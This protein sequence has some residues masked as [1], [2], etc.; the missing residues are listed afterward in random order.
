MSRVW[1]T[2]DTHFSHKFLALDI[3]GF[4]TIEAHDEAIVENWNS[5][6]NPDDHVWHLGDVSLNK[7]EKFSSFTRRLNGHKHL[8][9]GNHDV[10]AGSDRD[11]YKFTKDYISAG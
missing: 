6:V 9:F 3:R 10:G 7:P 2:A 5:V 1:V 4:D 8:V 11:S